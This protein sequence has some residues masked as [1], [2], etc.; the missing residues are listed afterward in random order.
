MTKRYQVFIS[1]TFT[2][3]KEE[4][5]EVMKALLELDCIPTG[6]ELFPASDDTQWDVIKSIIDNCDY[7]ILILAGRYGSINKDGVGYT[8]LEYNYANE[9]GIPTIAFL[10]ENI[11][12]LSVSK[13]E[14]TDEG[15]EKLNNFRGKVQ[16]KLCKYW[17]T[18]QELG[19][20]VSRSLIQLI[21]NKPAVG[22]VK[23]DNIISSDAA[24]EILK[25]KKYIEE[26]ENKNDFEPTDTDQFKQGN[27]IFN[28]RFNF[29][30]RDINTHKRGM[31]DFDFSLY[32]DNSYEATSNDITWNDIF[33]S[34]S[35][36]M[37]NE[38][39]EYEITTAI[40]KLIEQKEYSNLIESF[41]NAD[42][43]NFRIIPEDFQTI[44]VQLRAL[45]LIVRSEKKRKI[46]DNNTYWSLSKYGD[47]LMTK[48]RA[49]K[50]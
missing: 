9:K 5:N 48:L 47:N 40:N 3:L 8:E 21:K 46:D 41:E 31:F 29:N 19:S 1:S 32:D 15:K 10:H 2:D 7:Y 45:K 36:L 13:S 43:V 44:I 24:A 18:P 30:V 11:N 37:I 34:I 6:M 25:L 28:L 14:N 33:Y 35:P 22:W 49:L 39:N 16:N 4:R 50:K 20:V 26:L 38:A 17:N 42:L 27:D 12:N 23:A